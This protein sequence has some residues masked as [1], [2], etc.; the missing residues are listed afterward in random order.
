MLNLIIKDILV[1][2]KLLVFYIATIIIYLLLDASTVFIAIIYSIIFIKHAFSID[3]KDNVNILLN[4]LP[5]TRKEIVSSKYIGAIVFTVTIIV[6]TYL[7]SFLLN[8]ENIAV[9]WKEILLIMGLVMITLALILPLSYKFKSQYLAIASIVL[10]G[11]YLFIITF[12]IPHFNDSVRQLIHK[13]MILP[14]VQ[15]YMIT[16]IPIIILYVGSWLL[17]VRIYERK[18]F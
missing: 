7:G 4:S 1:Q 13:F 6:I 12:I 9:V 17:S 5:Y 11:I 14:E 15:M 2:K 10:F 8:G 18:V 16:I 3:E